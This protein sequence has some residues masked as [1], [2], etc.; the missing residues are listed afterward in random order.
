MPVATVPAPR[1]S[2][3]PPADEATPHQ[4]DNVLNE[5][6]ATKQ[7]AQTAPKSIHATAEHESDTETDNNELQKKINDESTDLLMAEFQSKQTHYFEHQDE[8]DFILAS[9]SMF[10][11]QV[12]ATLNS[13]RKLSNPRF[14][15]EEHQ[16]NDSIQTSVGNV[17]GHDSENGTYKGQGQP[18]SSVQGSLVPAAE[19][20]LRRTK[21]PSSEA[22][23]QDEDDTVSASVSEHGV[24]TVP[25]Q[26]PDG[27]HSPSAGTARS[28]KEARSPD[29]G[30]PWPPPDGAA[31]LQFAVVASMCVYSAYTLYC[32]RFH[33][34][35]V[36]ILFFLWDKVSHAVIA[37][38]PK[39]TRGISTECEGD[40]TGDPIRPEP[41]QQMHTAVD[42]RACNAKHGRRNDI[43]VLEKTKR[44]DMLHDDHVDVTDRN[45]DQNNEDLADSSGESHG[46]GNS[47]NG[48]KGGNK[49]QRQSWGGSG[50]GQKGPGGAG[51]CTGGCGGG[52]GSGGSGGR[53]DKGDDKERKD[54]KADANNK[55]DDGENEDEEEDTA[56][57]QRSDNGGQQQNPGVDVACSTAVENIATATATGPVSREQSLLTVLPY[58]GRVASLQ[59]QNLMQTFLRSLYFIGEASWSVYFIGE[60]SCVAVHLYWGRHVHL[61][62]LA[63][64][65]GG[66]VDSRPGAVSRAGR[67]R[68]TVTVIH[69]ILTP[70]PRATMLFSVGLLLARAGSISSAISLTAPA[71]A[72]L[73]SRVSISGES[74]GNSTLSILTV[75][76]EYVCAANPPYTILW[77][78]GQSTPPPSQCDQ[79]AVAGTHCCSCTRLAGCDQRARCRW[80]HRPRP[81]TDMALSAPKI[82]SADGR[83][84]PSS[85]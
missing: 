33:L 65:D 71:A 60:A 79:R 37:G 26:E 69:W 43:S 77:G 29:Q 9:V 52:S 67:A 82:T 16:V 81:G 30:C 1:A 23:G 25:R 80:R 72:D 70:A 31:V 12:L 68:V 62:W 2:S 85:F 64:V 5:D 63:A 4:H 66:G 57:N 35:C 78:G 56:D 18:T 11:V 48:D 59:I 83:D 73:L 27:C 47:S 28:S 6:V 54:K 58:S 84:S 14:S 34:I 53:D 75:L 19:P 40:E 3:P 32:Y 38:R 55:K 17:T 10:I 13:F 39:E 44:H 49:E 50:Q 76:Q 61:V 15:Y 74:R 24:Q 51:G 20:I 22:A 21:R 46:G 7:C 42:R 8:H 41:E 36:F 45:G